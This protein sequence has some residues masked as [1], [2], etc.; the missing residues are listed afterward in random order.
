MMPITRQQVEILLDNPAQRNYVVSAYA[1]MRVRDGFRRHLELSLNNE[2]RSAAAALAE[3]A[4]RKDLDAN[5]AVIREAVAEASPTARGLAVFSGVSR[6]LRQVIPLE[7]PVEN[8]LVID[9]EP[10]LLPLLEHWYGEPSFL[11]ALFDANEAHLFERHHGRPEP[12]RDL[13]RE[14]V[15]QDIQ[16]DKPRFTVK[17][18]FASTHHERL[19]GNDDAPFLHELSDAIAGRWKDGNFAGLILLGQSQETAALRGILPKGLDALV[20]GEAPHAMTGGAGD[21]NDVVSRLVDDWR[22]EQQRQILAELNERRKQD[23]LVANGATEVLDALQ[24]G[25]AAQVLFGIRRDMP[26]ARCPDCGYR[27]GAPIGEC[28]YCGARCQS[29]NAAQD[30][31]RLAV[32]HRVPVVL[33][34][35]PARDDT[36][37]PAG[38][39]AALLRAGDN[40]APRAEVPQESKD[41]AQVF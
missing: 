34:R 24:Q 35:A 40:W 41:H 5:I 8:R 18:R 11:I 17:K 33:F 6:G 32:R 16:R 27:F 26:G 15:A 10:F 38:G 14:D 30:I 22:L 25:R 4:A 36:L 20:V 2:A 23:H 21:L 12:V 39:V 29:V 37:G 19:H 7:F 13:E 9:E 3:A 1:D 31:L 28:L